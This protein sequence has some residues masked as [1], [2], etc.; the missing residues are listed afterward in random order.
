MLEVELRWCFNTNAPRAGSACTSEQPSWPMCNYV[1]TYVIGW[2]SYC[3]ACVRTPWFNLDCCLCAANCL[4]HSTIRVCVRIY[5]CQSHGRLSENSFLST[6][7]H[8]CMI[9]TWKYEY[10]YRVIVFLNICT[11]VCIYVYTYTYTYI[12]TYIYIYIYI[13]MAASHFGC[14][15]E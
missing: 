8:G 3:H 13:Y 11:Y 4:K 7:L 15:Q 5:D 10:I 1:R 12:Y 9:H 14:S 6:V 2:G